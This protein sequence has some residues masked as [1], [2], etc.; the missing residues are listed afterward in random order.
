MCRS[1]DVGVDI[2]GVNEGNHAG[3]RLTIRSDEYLDFAVRAL[4]HDGLKVPPFELHGPGTGDLRR[5]GLDGR[6]WVAWVRTNASAHVVSLAALGRNDPD[7]QIGALLQAGS[8]LKALQDLSASASLNEALQ[9]F[10]G[11]S[12]RKLPSL[13]IADPAT[14]SPDEVGR[15]LDQMSMDEAPGT[16]DRILVISI[17]NYERLVAMRV[18]PASVLVG[19]EGGHPDWSTLR[20]AIFAASDPPTEFV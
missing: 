17:V 1:V 6:V 4:V 16:S 20:G 15:V 3:W 14:L 7:E 5:R 10:D 13:V 2:S 11:G 9:N 8:P 12:R 19:S 18:G